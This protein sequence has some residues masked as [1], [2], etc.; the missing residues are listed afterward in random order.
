MRVRM[1]AGA[2][3]TGGGAHLHIVAGFLQSLDFFLE[4]IQALLELI[5]RSRDVSIL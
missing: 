4:R 1:T 2:E 3:Q 5:K